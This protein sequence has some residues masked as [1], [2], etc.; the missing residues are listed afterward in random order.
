[1]SR[2]DYD[3]YDEQDNQ[4]KGFSAFGGHLL[5]PAGGAATAE[6]EEGDADSS[7]FAALGIQ[8]A[9]QL[10]AIAAIPGVREELLSALG[11]E[12]DEVQAV[13]DRVEHD[14]PADRFAMLSAPAPAEFG[15][16]VLPPTEEIRAA[17]ESSARELTAEA[18]AV[19][20]PAGVNLIPWMSAIRNQ[21]PR[22]TCVSFTLTALNEYILRR[23]G[24]PRD[25]SEQH[26]YYEIK[27]IDGSPSGCGTWQT[28]AV[29]ALLNRGQCRE[30]VW[31]YNPAPPCN[32]HGPRPASA[33]P[34]GLNHRLRTLA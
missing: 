6:A 2:T 32:N 28:K 22:G 9:E 30:T 5:R 7:P 33:R 25:L 13:I 24:M 14:L 12:A 16:G 3:D 34:D 20:L 29:T 18:G 17:A 23:R 1:M 11:M 10:I 8:D 15:L 4:A 31:P 26:L 21:G 27:L 19:A